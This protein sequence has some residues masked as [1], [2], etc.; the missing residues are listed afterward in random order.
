MA[1][2][3]GTDD[4]QDALDQLLGTPSVNEI[5]TEQGRLMAAR[6]LVEQVGEKGDI[7]ANDWVSSHLVDLLSERGEVSDQSQARL[8]SAY[9]HFAED[10][11]LTHDEFAVI[12]AFHAD[13]AEKYR[14]YVAAVDQV[15]HAAATVAATAVAIVVTIATAGAGAP[16]AASLLATYG[17]AALA[18][19]LAGATA[20]V[21][22]A[23]LLGG[24]H[25]DALS[26]EGL[27]EGATGFAE[28]AMAALSVGLANRFIGMVGLGGS[29]LTGEMSAGILEASDA[30]LALGGKAYRLGT[31][32][33]AIQGFLIGSVGEI[34]LTTADEATW[35][36]SIWGVIQ[37]YGVAIIRGGGPGALMGAALGGPLEALTTYLGAAKLQ[38]LLIRL[39]EAGMV[40]A[41]L[42]TMSVGAA[43][44]VG[45]VN[46]ALSTGD[47][48][49]AMKAI[50][51]LQGEMTPDEIEL[52]WRTLGKFNLGADP[53]PLPRL[54]RTTATEPPA[55]TLAAKPSEPLSGASPTGAVKRP[56]AVLPNGRQIPPTSY[57]GGY[58]APGEPISVEEA[59]EK[60]L[61]ARGSDW[62]LLEHVQPR[63]EAAMPE[64]GGSAFRGTTATPSSIGDMSGQGAADWAGEGGIIFEIRN[65]PTWHVEQA[66]EGQIKDPN[67]LFGGKLL[68]KPEVE[69]AVPARV[70]PECIVRAGK[71][72]LFPNG[73]LGVRPGDWIPNPNYRPPVVK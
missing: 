4:L 46:V 8:I 59:F 63:S 68:V 19:G 69:S 44:I 54:G 67:G 56:M 3:L 26:T 73:R 61:P 20:S 11:Q 17:P 27:K 28:G 72:S 29:V 53:G 32:R 25:H 47:T 23:E 49:G 2:E 42:N 1:S 7:R 65:V 66:L 34:V 39:E 5:L 9:R 52:L 45:D 57:A 14:E 41:R 36:K 35:R 38:R 12:A 62:R 58:H 15:A 51:G 22:S 18:G 43:R 33:G 13:F 55:S 60:G 71:V 48:V 24:S 30:A 50:V 64:L 21:A 40:R 6:I 31:L 16:A 10:G 37:R 70:P